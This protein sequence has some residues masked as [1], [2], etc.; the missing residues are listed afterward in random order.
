MTIIRVEKRKSY[1]VMDKTGLDDEKLS[2]K[3]KGLLTYLLSKP[4]NW[5]CYREH[6]A[7]V[8]PD[9]LTAVR[10][11]LKELRDAG[12]LEKRPI[13]GDDGK[14]EEWESILREQP[15]TPKLREVDQKVENPPAGYHTRWKSHQHN[16]YLCLIINELEIEEE[17]EAGNFLKKFSQKFDQIFK[18]ELSLELFEKMAKL[19]F[20]S[21]ILLKAI[22]LAEV[23]A[24]QPAYILRILQD[25]QKQKL[26]NVIEVEKYIE[27]RKSS[28]K[29]GAYA[30]DQSVN[31]DE[32]EANGWQ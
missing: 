27:K 29:P 5:H 26:T 20:S 31:V 14:I 2:F 7:K 28:S 1:L 30:S 23:N 24:D 6:L 18:K 17:E 12:Y 19:S 10:S 16:K 9:G 15:K 25:W 13:R 11:G 8:G 22:Y 3:A 32:M 21:S 4:D